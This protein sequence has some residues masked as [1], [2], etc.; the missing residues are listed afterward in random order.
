M[1]T[2]G[3]G[4]CLGLGLRLRLGLGL[5]LRLGLGLRLGLEYA[6]VEVLLTTIGYTVTIKYIGIFFIKNPSSGIWSY[7]FSIMQ[8]FFG[9]TAMSILILKAIF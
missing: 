2:K 3:L 6:K 1:T 5:R 8:I 7:P 4:L 9:V